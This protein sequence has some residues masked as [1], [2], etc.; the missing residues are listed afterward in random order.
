MI[1]LG[2]SLPPYPEA[3]KIDVN[4]VAGCESKVWLH[5]HKIADHHHFL[6]DSEAKIIRGLLAVILTAINQKSTQTILQFD[7]MAYLTQLGLAHHLSASR[8]NGLQQIFTQIR[9]YLKN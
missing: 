7:P 3:A 2:D 4:L 8:S 9:S 5:H 6:I 1:T